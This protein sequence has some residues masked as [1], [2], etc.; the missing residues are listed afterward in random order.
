MRALWVTI[1]LLAALGCGAF[2]VPGRACRQ[3]E[4]CAGLKDGYCSRAEICTK[5]C[6]DT[7][8]CPDNSLC[9]DMGRRAVC[10]PKCENDDGCFAGFTCFDGVCQVKA[11]LAPPVN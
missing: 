4:D 1:A 7:D 10:L 11:P 6:S 3:H 8:P 5:E 2:A 9:K